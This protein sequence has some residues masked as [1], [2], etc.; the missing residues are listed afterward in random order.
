MAGR[1][2]RRERRGKKKERKKI[3]KNR[4]YSS[5]LSFLEEKNEVNFEVTLALIQRER[6]NEGERE[7]R[8]ER[9]GS[10]T[11]VSPSPSP[12]PCPYRQ[13]AL[14]LW[15]PWECHWRRRQGATSWM[16]G[17]PASRSPGELWREGGGY[18]QEPTSQE[19]KKT[20]RT[21]SLCVIVLALFNILVAASSILLHVHGAILALLLF[22]SLGCSRG[23]ISR[24]RQ[25]SPLP[26][27]WK[28]E[29]CWVL[30]VTHMNK[31]NEGGG[32]GH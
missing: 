3:R 24:V 14:L 1:V 9:R 7:R 11:V 12:S 16:T 20:S 18:E 25:D 31:E 22:F 10:L 28:Y 21:L 19:K 30:E 5:A 8:R 17:S 23:W 4:D 6:R 15:L 13:P 2:E 27:L 32:G 29:Q 26:F